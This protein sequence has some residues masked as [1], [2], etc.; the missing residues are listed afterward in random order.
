MVA[1]PSTQVTTVNP[2]YAQIATTMAHTFPAEAARI[3]R[4]LDVLATRRIL[5]TPELGVYLVQSGDNGG[6]TLTTLV[7]VDPVWVYFDVDDL[8]FME[9]NRL[10][11]T[12]PTQSEYRPKVF[13]GLAHEQMIGRTLFEVLQTD[14]PE[15]E[16]IQMH[17][18]ALELRG[19]V[20]GAEH[21][22]T[23]ASMNDLVLVLESQGKYEAAE[24]VHRRALELYKKVLGAEH[25]HTLTSTNNLAKNPKISQ[26]PRPPP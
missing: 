23:L 25:P 9:V 6:T 15:H 26:P 5:D 12:S 19:K 14:D 7:S 4:A 10:S 21:P 16:P 24:E 2:L 22:D 18:R 1:T 17:R 20:L 3:T 13:L 8:T 11:H